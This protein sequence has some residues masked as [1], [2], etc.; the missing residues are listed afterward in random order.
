MGFRKFDRKWRRSLGHDGNRIWKMS[1]KIKK[2]VFRWRWRVQFSF[3]SK[4]C[5]KTFEKF[6]QKYDFRVEPSGLCVSCEMSNWIF[7]EIDSRQRGFKFCPYWKNRK[8]KF[9]HTKRSLQST[10][11]NCICTMYL[12]PLIYRWIISMIHFNF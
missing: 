1:E 5:Q 12:Y 11:Y 3:F 8:Q 4:I 10:F 9:F 6:S 7:A 2:I